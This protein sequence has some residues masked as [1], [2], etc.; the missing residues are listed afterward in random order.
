MLSLC[1]NDITRYIA[2]YNDISCFVKGIYLTSSHKWGVQ[3][4]IAPLPG[5][6]AAHPGD[7]EARPEKLFFPFLP[8][9]VTNN[10]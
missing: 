8:P 1:Y 4:G 10:E 2:N 6:G 3:R 5:F 7:A 9:Q